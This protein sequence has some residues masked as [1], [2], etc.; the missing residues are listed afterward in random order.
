MIRMSHGAALMDALSMEMESDPAISVI[1]SYI[2]GLGPPK[3]HADALRDR[4]PDRVFDPPSAE[5]AITMLAVGAALAGGRPFVS[6]GTASFSLVAWS[7]LTN[8]AANVHLQSGGKARAPAVFHMLHGVRAGAAPQHA[9]SPQAQFWN[10]PGLEI[11]M[12][13]TPADARGLMLSALRSPNPTIFLDH[14]RLLNEEG[15]VETGD[16]PVPFG[17][18]IVR[19]EGGDL[20]I[21]A[22]SAM[23]PVA[24]EGAEELAAQGIAAEVW[25]PRT[26]VPFDRE[27]LLASVEKT[28]RLMILDECVLEGSTASEIAAKV[29]EARF[30]A[31]KA[32]IRR[33]ARPAMPAPFSAPLE[34]MM[35][36]S[37][38]DVVS[39]GQAM[40]AGRGGN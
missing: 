12:P 26:L 32:P 35:R 21:V 15:K 11:V 38:R 36:P 33:L 39:V 1:G 23:V 37:V 34:D 6:I 31:L 4:F 20:T 30:D 25:D 13:A 2:L 3:L 40:M 10:A 17:Q 22:T 14:A 29:A 5:A 28:G 24:L 8:E 7:Q 18:G 16:A 27:G 19:R 9:A